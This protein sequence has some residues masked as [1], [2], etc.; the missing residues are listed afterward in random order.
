MTGPESGE[1]LTEGLRILPLT[2]TRVGPLTMRSCNT[3]PKPQSVY[4]LS[5]WSLCRAIICNILVSEPKSTSNDL[6]M[7]TGG[8]MTF[9]DERQFVG[10]SDLHILL[11]HRLSITTSSCLLRIS[12]L[13][14]GSA[15]RLNPCFRTC[16]DFAPSGSLHSYL[17]R[18]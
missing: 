9:Q 6:P 7:A 11:H 12:M 4:D 18:M 14:K 3:I 5:N 10:S 1:N 13:L 8:V 2:R 17:S 16:G 15:T